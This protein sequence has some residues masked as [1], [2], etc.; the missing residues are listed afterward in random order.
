[1]TQYRTRQEWIEVPRM[2]GAPDG[3][4]ATLDTF[5]W[6]ATAA[7]V[8]VEPRLSTLATLVEGCAIGRGITETAWRGVDGIASAFL[9]PA[10]SVPQVVAVSAMSLAVASDLHG[11]VVL[12][13][14]Q[15]ALRLLAAEAR[16]EQR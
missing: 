5:A 6:T 7:V 3:D 15:T 11:E 4:P 13:R 14:Y 2:M 10:R 16:R 12:R 1:M 9:G 8:E